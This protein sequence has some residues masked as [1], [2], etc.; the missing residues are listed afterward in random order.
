MTLDF[1]I[2]TFRFFKPRNTYWFIPS[3]DIYDFSAPDGVNFYFTWAGY[4]NP[5]LN[6]PYSSITMYQ[7]T[8]NIPSYEEILLDIQLVLRKAKEAGTNDFQTFKADVGQ[9]VFVVD[10]FTP[11]GKGLITINDVPN[12]DLWNIMGNTYTW[13]GAALNLGDIVRIWK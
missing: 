3:V 4:T 2:N 7:G 11:S 5:P 6:I 9:T 10:Q 1:D 13:T 8:R 12:M